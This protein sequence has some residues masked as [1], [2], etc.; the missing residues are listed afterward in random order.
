MNP[1]D[2]QL[3]RDRAEQRC[4]YCRLGK[5]ALLGR[6]GLLGHDSL[7]SSVSTGLA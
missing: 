7:F 5:V 2:R 4:E 1:A 3:V 6:P